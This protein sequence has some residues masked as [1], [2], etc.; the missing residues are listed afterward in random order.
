MI[1]IIYIDILYINI[2]YKYYIE[3]SYI[4]FWLVCFVV[5]LHVFFLFLPF[6]VGVASSVLQSLQPILSLFFFFLGFVNE[7]N[8]DQ[9]KTRYIFSKYL[10]LY[11]FFF[12]TKFVEENLSITKTFLYFQKFKCE[13]WSNLMQSYCRRRFRFQTKKKKKFNYQKINREFKQK[14][15]FNYQKVNRE[16]KQKKKKKK[17]LNLGA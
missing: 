6:F 11:F 9:R 3:I 5:V 8:L 7:R 13:S 4:V 17:K 14:K 12:S 16:F 2:I 1:N 10:F 15:K